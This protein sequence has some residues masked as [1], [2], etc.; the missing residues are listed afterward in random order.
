M[1]P[2]RLPP[3]FSIIFSAG[4]NPLGWAIREAT[5]SRYSHVVIRRT[6]DD[7]DLIFEATGGHR[8]SL[9]PYSVYASRKADI[10]AE[11]A[12]DGDD[13]KLQ[14]AWDWGLTQFCDVP[15][16]W[17]QLPGDYWAII[18][19]KVQPKKRHR[20]P[21]AQRAL[22]CSELVGRVLRY[23]EMPGLSRT[24]MERVSPEELADIADAYSLA[25]RRR[26]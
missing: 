5:N 10:L 7:S 3:R 17:L 16:G 13:V 6:D 24:D 9:R 21:F 15:Y 26:S 23:A 14:R 4:K 25:Y 8:C 1:I 20:N 19:D 22:V 11:Y 18:A 12:L 2:Q